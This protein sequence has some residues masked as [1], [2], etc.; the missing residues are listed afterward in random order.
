MKAKNK[1]YSDCISTNVTCVK[2]NLPP[3]PCLGIE[4]GDT[5]DQVTFAII[6]KICS[7]FGSNDLSEIELT[8]ILERLDINQPSERTIAS[9]L[10]LAF[11]NDCRL[12]DLIQEV[13]G[14]ITNTTPLVLD[15]KCLRNLDAFGQPVP[16]NEQTVL[17][18]LINNVCLF[19]DQIADLSADIVTTNIRIDNLPAPYTEPNLTTCLSGTPKTT[20][21]TVVLMAAD[22]CLFKPKVGQIIKIDQ[23][24]GGQPTIVDN[25][26]PLF[27][28]PDLIPTPTSLADSDINQWV[29]IES[30]LERI[31]ALEACACKFDCDDIT[32]GF[33][34][35]FNDDQTVTLTFSSG[36]G[37]FIPNTFTDCG[38]KITISNDSGVKLGPIVIPI[39]Q[40]YESIDFDVSMFSPGEYL[41][42]SLDAKL[43]SDSIDCFKCVKK[44]VRNTSGCCVISNTGTEPITIIYKVC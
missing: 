20:S 11:D 1:L 7:S 19:I 40:N 37:S 12:Y 8:C 34:T 5:L 9:L 26:D 22:Y 24:I 25:T 39:A 42:F 6:E 35:T 13:R 17:Q 38:S 32:I 43:C 2:W 18:S 16:Y 44:V 30:L 14:L 21:Q 33:L 15:L 31:Q 41:T 10:Q 4:T 36:A 3:I 28:N 29:F 23:A 27:A